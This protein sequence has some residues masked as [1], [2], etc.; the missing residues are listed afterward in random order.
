MLATFNLDR[1]LLGE[2]TAELARLVK[3]NGIWKFENVSKPAMSLEGLLVSK[4]F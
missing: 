4:G 2:H 3:V 1:D